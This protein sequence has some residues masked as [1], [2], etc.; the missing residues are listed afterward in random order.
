MSAQEHV[1]SITRWELQKFAILHTSRVLW[2]MC[3]AWIT[4]W[5]VSGSI[6]TTDRPRHTRREYQEFAILQASGSLM[7]DMP[8]LEYP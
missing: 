3:H 1:T 4:H 7:A 6:L 2:K 5:I 8:C